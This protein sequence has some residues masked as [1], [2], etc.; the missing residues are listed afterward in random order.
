MKRF[1]IASLIVVFLFASISIIVVTVNAQN[2]NEI[3]LRVTLTVEGVIDTYDDDPDELLDPLYYIWIDASGNPNDGGYGN[4]QGT[5]QTG[6]QLG[7]EWTQIDSSQLHFW[8]PGID[9]ITG[10]GDDENWYISETT[11]GS[12]KTWR[13]NNVEASISADGRSLIVTFPLSKIG[14][15]TTLEVSFMTATSTSAS[16]DN[17][18]PTD[19][20]S[21]GIQGWIGYPA[22]I[23]ATTSGLYSKNDA[24]ET[25]AADFDITSGSVEI[26]ESPQIYENQRET[27][28]AEVILPVG[29]IVVAL[30][31]LLA[32]LGPMVSSA[33]SNLPVPKSVKSFLKFYGASIFSKG[34]KIKIKVLED[35]KFLT[36]AELITLVFTVLITT[37]IYGLVETNGFS[38]FLIPEV[39][40]TVIPSILLSV[41]I[42]TIT[43]VIS[44]AFWAKTYKVYKQFSVWIIGLVMFIITGVLFLFPF[45]SPSI[46][47]YQSE[48]LSKETK[49]Y[50]VIFKTFTLLTLLIPF[51]ILFMLGFQIIGDSGL[52]LTLMSA[53][54]SLVPL[55]FLAGKVLFDYRKEISI[56]MLFAIAFLFYGCTLNLLPQ[57][58]F[59]A[60]GVASAVIA[61]VTQKRLKK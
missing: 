34:D 14:S 60:A 52:L 9:G 59:L 53:C 4:G 35:S 27:P 43:K 23:D 38:N 21:Q 54:Y 6:I 29:A 32:N 26:F 28:L 51:S 48:E 30:T 37:L 2:G 19:P 49:A 8:G 40:A 41:G 7:A 46:T 42:I 44:N 36:K 18:H 3:N 45:S 10:T 55:K 15:P 58:I 57:V 31:A 39:F 11:P 17:L 5:Y 1:L 12:S 50:L 16:T 20:L 24:V 13:G 61:F 56:V 33:I 22:S 47:R 25:I